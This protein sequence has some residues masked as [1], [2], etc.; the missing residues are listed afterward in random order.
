MSIATRHVQRIPPITGHGLHV[1]TLA[2]QQRDNV[3]KTVA[4]SDVQ[5]RRTVF[6]GHVHARTS[7]EERNGN[8][9]LVILGGDME[10]RPA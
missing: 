10:R 9:K 7:P 4:G 6:A 1:C 2:Q 8:I 3:G 5:C